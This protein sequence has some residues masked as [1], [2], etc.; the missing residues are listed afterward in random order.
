MSSDKKTGKQIKEL[1]SLAKS[2]GCARS[3]GAAQTPLLP[4]KTIPRRDCEKLI[5]KLS[6]DLQVDSVLLYLIN[7]ESSLPFF[8]AGIGLNS[9][10]STKRGGQSWKGL[11][12][13]V[14]QKHDI[15]SI[16]DIWIDQATLARKELFRTEGFVSYQGIPLAKKGRLLGVLETFDREKRSRE[17]YWFFQFRDFAKRLSGKINQ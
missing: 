15:V 3:R 1:P 17:A 12:W 10:L 5:S 9:D 4:P 14:I 16:T 2:L 8:F 7:P 13:R 11:T 6:F